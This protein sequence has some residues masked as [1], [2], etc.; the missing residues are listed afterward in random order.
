MKYIVIIA[1]VLILGSLASAFVFMMKKGDSDHHRAK[2]MVNSLTVR[3]S[4]SVLLFST[5]LLAWYFGLI[6]PTGRP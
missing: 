1:F 6:T 4:I 3:I 5:I 2:R